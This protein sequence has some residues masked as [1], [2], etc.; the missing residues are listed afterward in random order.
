[1][2]SRPVSGEAA[3]CL[4][5]SE[6]RLKPQLQSRQHLWFLLKR[7]LQTIFWKSIAKAGSGPIIQRLV[8]N[9]PPQMFQ[10][11]HA[12]GTTCTMRPNRDA[13]GARPGPL[14]SESKL[15]TCTLCFWLRTCKAGRCVRHS[16]L[17]VLIVSSCSLGVKGIANAFHERSHILLA[18]CPAQLSRV[19]CKYI[20]RVKC[21]EAMWKDVEWHQNAWNHREQTHPKK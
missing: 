15:S 5:S 19:Q 6:V 21:H 13:H 10:W 1:M 18:Q 8:A 17:Q 7:M 14:C 12:C 2:Q 3:A 9:A 4:T 11:A 16:R 20:S